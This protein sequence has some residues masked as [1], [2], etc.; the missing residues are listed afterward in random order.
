M[1]ADTSHVMT[2]DQVA[3]KT[4]YLTL[5]TCVGFALAVALFVL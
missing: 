1:A 2:G 3:R 4:F 5:A